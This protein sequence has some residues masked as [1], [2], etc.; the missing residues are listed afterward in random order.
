M[1][2]SH[3]PTVNPRYWTAITLASICGT[4]LGDLYAHT[5]H[6]GIVQGLLILCAI[7]AAA[8]IAERSDNAAHESYYW[9]VIIIIRTGATNI[10]DYLAF[11]V[12]VPMVLLI[13]GLAA[14]LGVLAWKA[15]AGED[16][17]TAQAPILPDTGGIYWVAMLIAGVFGTVLG[18]VVSHAVGQGIASLGLGFILASVMWW[19]KNGVATPGIGLYWLTVATARTAGTAIGDWLAENKIMNL[20]LPLC[21]A[22]TVCAFLFILLAFP[23]RRAARVTPA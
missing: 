20:G 6:F 21:T 5:T 18:D 23:G 12:H 14:T 11:R 7:A 3:M 1:K 4:N 8:F 22:M 13:A 15:K 19:R 16:A 17:Q 10:A 9:L 2:T